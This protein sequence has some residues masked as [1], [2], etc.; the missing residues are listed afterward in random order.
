MF[1][2]GIWF[3]L[4]RGSALNL[5]RA[6]VPPAASSVATPT[7][8]PTPTVPQTYL[9]KIFRENLRTSLSILL[10]Q[11]IVIIIVA[12]LFAAVF[13]RVGQPPVMGEM[14]AGIVLGPS[15]LGLLSP[16]TMALLF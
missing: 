10:L 16:P 6:A 2:A 1:A 8:A 4:A 3:I 12:R 14:I 9:A 11:I 15:L 13:R 7:P 5:N